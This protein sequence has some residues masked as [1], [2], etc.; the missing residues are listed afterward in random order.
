MLTHSRVSDASCDSTVS[1]SIV[2]CRNPSNKRVSSG[3]LKSLTKRERERRLKIYMHTLQCL[4]TSVCI[5][6]HF[7]RTWNIFDANI[8]FLVL[9]FLL[10]EGEVSSNFS[11]RDLTGPEGKIFYLC[12]PLSHLFISFIILSPFLFLFPLSLSLLPYLKW[13]RQC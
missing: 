4:C 5:W 3:S 13:C 8:K 2:F 1:L 11:P 12:A 7:I 9:I 6:I 10:F